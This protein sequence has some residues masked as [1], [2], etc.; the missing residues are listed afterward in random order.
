[1]A[2]ERSVFPF[3]TLPFALL[4]LIAPSVRLGEIDI[5]EARGNG[6]K[7]THQSDLFFFFQMLCARLL[8]PGCSH[9]QGTGLDSSLVELGTYNV[10][11]RRGED[12]WRVAFEER[13]V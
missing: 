8:M 7:Y 1:M 3:P 2:V 4:E 9:T 6:Y 10:A 13:H 11:Q 5:M 12:V